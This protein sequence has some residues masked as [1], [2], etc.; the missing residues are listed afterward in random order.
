M[1]QTFQ[2]VAA[3][4]PDPIRIENVV[5]D[6]P[7]G[8]LIADPGFDVAESTAVALNADGYRYDVIKGYRLVAAVAASDTTIKIA[9]G[10]GIV[11]DD[12]LGYGTKSVA[13]TAIDQSNADYDLV[14]VTMGISIASGEVL[15]QASAASA[16][17]AQIIH[18]PVFVLGTPVIGNNGDQEAALIAIGTLRKETCCIGKDVASVLGTIKI[19]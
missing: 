14:T 6:K 18:T 2:Y 19:V 17:A 9:K 8:G 5:A 3:E 16:N 11:K 10:S 13:C 15:Y 7:G 4:N 1:K 12:F